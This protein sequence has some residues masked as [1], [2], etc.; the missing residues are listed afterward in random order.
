MQLP[1]M[2]VVQFHSL[3]FP[4][5][6]SAQ[7]AI[8]AI[9]YTGMSYVLVTE[10]SC[11]VGLLTERDFV[12]AIAS[13]ID[14]TATPLAKLLTPLIATYRQVEQVEILALLKILQQHQIQH[15]PVL[16]HA[17]ELNGTSEL[18]GV[19]TPE[20][21]QAAIHPEDIFMQT[22]IHGLISNSG[23]HAPAH[24]PLSQLANLM[25]EKQAGYVVIVGTN[26]S[27]IAPIGMITQQDLIQ[28]AASDCCF[29]TTTAL[30]VV[31]FPSNITHTQESCWQAQQQ[32]Q[33]LRMQRL[34]VPATLEELD[35]DVPQADLMRETDPVLLRGRIAALQETLE[36]QTHKLQQEIWERQ[37]LAQELA[38]SKQRYRGILNHLPDLIC[39][40]R[41]DGIVTFANQAYCQYFN[42]SLPEILAH[43]FFDCPA[44]ANQPVSLARLIQLATNQDHITYQH[45]VARNGTLCWLEWTYVAICNEEGDLIEFQAIGRDITERL[46]VEQKLRD[47]EARNRAILNAIPDVLLRV[48]RDGSCLDCV[49]PADSQNCSFSYIQQHIA[50]ALPLEAVQVRL[51][52]ID[53][54]LA[55]G[56]LQIVEDQFIRAGKVIHEEV[57]I[58]ACSKDEV[59]LMVRDLTQRRQSEVQFQRLAEHVPGVV[60]RYVLSAEGIDYINYI[61]PRCQEILGLTPEEIQ[62]DINVLQ[63]LIHPDDMIALKQKVLSADPILQPWQMEFRVVSPLGLKWIRVFAHPESQANG[64]TLWDGL[65][66]DITENKQAIDALHASEARF[67]AVF[68]QAAV[69]ITQSCLTGQYLQANQ[70][71]CQLLGYTETELLQHTLQDLTHPEDWQHNQDL[72]Q[73]LV[74]GKISAFSLEKRY[75]RKDGQVRW[76]HVSSSLVQDELYQQQY[77]LSVIEDI[78]ERKQ[79]EAELNTQQAF[80]RQVIDAVSSAIFVKDPM[81]RFVTANQASADIY[82]VSVEE[83]IGK[84]DLEFNDDADQIEEFWQTNRQVLETLQPQVIPSQ[85]LRH[86]SGKTLWY[87]TTIS[88]FM[89]AAGQLQGV[90][91][92]V[93]DITD[94]KQT[95]AALRQA[96]DAAEAANLAKSQFLANMSHELRTPL[97]SILGFAQLLSQDR[98]FTVEQQE[99][100]KII[101]H[102]GEHLLALIND[103]LEMSKIDAGK[104]ELNIESFNLYQMLSNLKQMLHIKAANKGIYLIFDRASD[105]PKY[106]QTDENK[107]RQVLINLLGNAV[108]FTSKGQV[109]LRVYLAPISQP[110]RSTNQK[111]DRTLQSLDTLDQAFFPQFTKPPT[112]LLC[113]EVQDTGPGIA[114]SELEHLFDPFVQTEVGRQSQEGTGLGLAISR[115]FIELM[116]GVIQV[117]STP[118]QGSTFSFQI[119]VCPIQSE[120]LIPSRVHL[121]IVPLVPDQSPLRILVVEDQLTNRQLVVQLLSRVGFEVREAIHGLDAIEQWEAWSPHLILMD[122]RMPMM[123]GYEATQQIRQHEQQRQTLD[124]AQSQPTIIIAL[125][126]SAFEEERLISFKAG[127][128]GYI[129]KPF[130]AEELLT[131][132]A[133][134]L[135]IAHLPPAASL[136]SSGLE[137]S[138]AGYSSLILPFRPLLSE[139]LNIMSASWKE[140]LQQAAAQLD[141]ECCLEWIQAVPDEASD[142]REAL[143]ILVHEFRFDVLIDLT[144]IDVAEC[145]AIDDICSG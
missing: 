11:L 40:F 57:R 2:Q 41:A 131:V 110:V 38:E 51:E 61:S 111:P 116:G 109:L 115:R 88:P 5:T 68:E 142:L 29:R 78:Q 123:D 95:E 107:L 134:Q 27:R 84:T 87:R 64:D 94:L 30:D 1:L 135:G 99:Y 58:V 22:C 74:S 15:L 120:A 128:N 105:V 17:A 101:L 122:M 81:Q 124:S 93:S 82:G 127:C 52:A 55:T 9:S 31:N 26:G 75:I 37:Q 73:K 46:N 36:T 130:K 79:A 98:A 76:A 137:E 143:Q 77:L 83:M 86:A 39:C 44:A 140:N 53:R 71:F 90:I 23:V 25:V 19:I 114:A 35:R 60:Y 139:D 65:A 32:I 145:N 133:E 33:D 12:R 28:L 97:N 59:L 118:G 125:T 54:A 48:K 4:A 144:R 69:G 119:P 100:L 72:L 89:D 62:Q 47:D 136:Q 70:W 21:I 91:G 63:S 104:I 50:E 14:L 112:L 18:V 20:R 16:S 42:Q 138:K 7:T 66:I 117:Q 56:E 13:G 121:P 92:V 43:H 102:S 141:S 49:V 80:L 108:K 106:I 24:I 34:I 45:R 103:I 113:F 132:I 10:D 85:A 8:H 126:A 96:K 3:V 6:E 67:R 129:P